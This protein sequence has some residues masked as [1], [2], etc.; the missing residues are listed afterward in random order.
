MVI[1]KTNGHKTQGNE[2]VDKGYGTILMKG[3]HHNITTPQ[4]YHILC[5]TQKHYHISTK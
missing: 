2:V 4:Q 3:K 5:P 1:Y